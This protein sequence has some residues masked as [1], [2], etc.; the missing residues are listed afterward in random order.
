MREL[1]AT[2]AALT[3]LVGLSL[4]AL[5]CAMSPRAKQETIYGPSESILEVV[6]VLRR[7]VPDDTYR[8]APATDFTGRNVYRSSLLRLESIERVHADELRAGHM[9]AVVA[10]SKAR[11]LERLRA[12]DLAGPHYALAGEADAVLRAEAERSEKICLAIAEAVT[13]GIDLIDPL[14]D[15]LDRPLLSADA[16]SVVA[17]LD[18]RIALLS[19]WIDATRGT[20]Y[21]FIL[22]EEIERSDV[23]RARYFGAMR[24][25]LPG[26]NIRAVAEHQRVVSRHAASH[27]RQRHLLALADL[28]GVLAEEY[29]E[30]NPPEGLRFDPP[31]FKELVDGASQIYQVVS[32]QDGTVEKLEAGRRLEALLAFALQVDRD[33]FSR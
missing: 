5:G 12:F 17:E 21:E 9:D 3:L 7:H 31:R 20:H 16:D 1:L 11:A 26:G 19:Q 29:V 24:Q 30:A 14:A 10:F 27:L 18:E 8:F 32:S 22:R 28:Y 6:A 2:S 4:G 25:V 23:T 15:D 33:R 13:I